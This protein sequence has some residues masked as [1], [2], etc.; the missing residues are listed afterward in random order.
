[1]DTHNPYIWGEYLKRYGYPKAI[2]LDYQLA[3]LSGGKFYSGDYGEFW[4]EM[5]E[6]ARIMMEIYDEKIEKVDRSIE[7]IFE[8]LEEKELLDDTVIIIT[9]D[10]GQSFFEHGVYSHLPTMYEEVIRVPII[11]IGEGLEGGM[12]EEMASHVD[13]PATLFSL[14]DVPIPRE[15]KGVNLLE[16]HRDVIFSEASHNELGYPLHRFV[17]DSSKELVFSFAIRK[18]KWKYITH[19][20]TNRRVEKLFDL[21]NDPNEYDDLSDVRYD[22]I[23]G[24]RNLLRGH[25]RSLDSV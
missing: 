25:L 14:L 19:I 20:S 22:I 11:I 13:I 23:E 2:F 8:A 5:A 21:E 3:K 24:M 7:R 12:R 16:D 17:L 9:S 18:G 6:I 1:M 4:D 15:F 10:H